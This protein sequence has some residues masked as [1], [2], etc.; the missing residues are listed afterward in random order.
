MFRYVF[1]IVLMT[2]LSLLVIFLLAVSCGNLKAMQFL[3]KHGVAV[4]C[5]EILKD[6]A[7]LKYVNSDGFAWLSIPDICYAPVMQNKKGFYRKH[8]F[9]KKENAFGEFYISSSNT[10][11][12]IKNFSLSEDKGNVF[13]LCMI[14]GSPYSGG[15]SLRHSNFSNLRGYAEEVKHGT[16]KDVEICD[17][18]GVHYYKVAMIIDIIKGSAQTGFNM[19][20]REGILESL[21]K[22]SDWHNDIPDKNANV[23]LLRYYTNIDNLTLVLY[24]VNKSEEVVK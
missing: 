11:E 13:D 20:S 15:S 14:T 24:E 8:N 17:S 4:F 1:L 22:M 19:T 6:F 21:E 5:K 9:L 2:L 18:N 12:G 16:A 7:L 10:A 3:A 23:L